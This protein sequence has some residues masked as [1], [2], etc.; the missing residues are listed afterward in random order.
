[1][2]LL[3][4]ALYMSR[5]KVLHLYY[6]HVWPPTGEADCPLAH[7]FLP[8]PRIL[9]K[10]PTGSLSLALP[11]PLPLIVSSARWYC[12][13]DLNRLTVAVVRRIAIAIAIPFGYRVA[14]AIAVAVAVALERGV[15]ISRD[16]RGSYGSMVR[17]GTR[18]SD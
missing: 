17:H 13:V 7:S 4:L 10:A 18:S 1:M 16:F 12:D 15:A 6:C 9:P 8:R 14:V 5:K 11:S 3:H 2:A